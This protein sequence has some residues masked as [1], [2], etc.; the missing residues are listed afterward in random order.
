[1]LVL[2]KIQKLEVVKKAEQGIY[3]GTMAER[4]LLPR[5]EVPE[6]IQ[7]GDELEVFVYRD[8]KDRL[9]CTTKK[10]YVTVGEIG[11]LT[12]KEV[13]KIGAFLDWGLEKD[14][15]LPF[16]EQT[17][18][19]KAG[20]EILAAVYIDKSNRLC[21]TMRLYPYLE[22]QS[23]YK[24][25]DV[26]TGYVYEVLENFGAFVAVDR[27]FT[28]MIPKKEVHGTIHAGEAVTAR[29]TGVKPDGKLDLSVQKKAYMQMQED[30][31]YI[32]QVIQEF[33]GVLPY[34]DKVA[35]GIIEKD[36]HMS[37][38]AFKRGVGHLLKEGKIEIGEKS[39]RIIK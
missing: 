33:A 13:S 9:I 17:Y 26:V 16:K 38:N 22:R 21:A 35:P 11:T 30:A 20:D 2:G 3:L 37:K 10:P 19:V 36:F 32:Y 12:V 25:D 15:F 4:V 7:I 23:T 8:S 28:G 31:D 34:N 14:L 18:K 1:M 39:I 6:E 24:K 27:K 5:K 29:V